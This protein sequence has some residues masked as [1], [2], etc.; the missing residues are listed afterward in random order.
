MPRMPSM[1]MRTMRAGGACQR[2]VS[3]RQAA[4][5]TVANAA[6]S[7]QRVTD[8]MAGPNWSTS[9]RPMT[10]L[11]AKQAGTR[12]SS[13]RFMRWRWGR[14]RG[15]S[16]HARVLPVHRRA[17]RMLDQRCANASLR[18]RSWSASD[19][20]GYWHRAGQL[21]SARSANREAFLESRRLSRS[22]EWRKLESRTEIL[23]ARAIPANVDGASA[24]AR[25]GRTAGSVPMATRR[26]RYHCRHRGESL[27]SGTYERLIALLDTH[28]ASY[29]LIDH[30]P[31]GQT[32]KVSALRG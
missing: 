17:S 22:S 7:A 12:A 32:D 19:A 13:R 28:K 25:T 27:M 15:G 1:P 26:D 6:D 8:R 20:I 23:P 16:C 31:E 10:G 29:R 2:S 24:V 18:K 9:A 5:S 3:E 4:R 11:S 30:P 21:A 14:P